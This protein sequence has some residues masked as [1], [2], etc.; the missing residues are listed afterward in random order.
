[1]DQAK[2]VLLR[3][4]PAVIDLLGPLPLDPRPLPRNRICHHSC[5]GGYVFPH[6]PFWGGASAQ[7]DLNC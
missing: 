2:D 1:M 6:L 4:D 7:D 5:V 3:A